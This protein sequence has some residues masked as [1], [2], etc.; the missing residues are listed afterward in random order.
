ML[1]LSEG[2]SFHLLD[3]I[4]LGSYFALLAASGAYFAWRARRQAHSA[5]AYFLGETAMPVWAVAISI[6]ATVQSAATF[7]GAPE[8]AF[9]GNLAYLGTSLG[10]V[11]AASLLATVFIPAYYRNGVGTPYQLLE[12]RFGSGAKLATSWAYMIGRV[13]ASGSRV[14]VGAIPVSIAVFGDASPIHMSASIAAFMA[15]GVVYTLAGGITSVIWTDVIQVAVYL[16]AAVLAVVLLAMKVSVPFSEVIGALASGGPGGSSKLAVFPTGFGEHGFDFA[17]EMNLVTMCTGFVLICLASHGTDQDLVQRMLTCKSAAR[18]AWS[19]VS[20]ILVGIPA[21]AVFM[22]LGLLLWVYYSRPELMG[23]STAHVS[24]VAGGEVLLRYIMNEM[25]AGAAGLMIAGVM[26][27]GPA[28]INSGLNSMAST[29]V[30]DVYKPRVS[31]RTDEH[32]L[33]VGRIAVLSWGVV[34]AAFALACIPWREHSGQSII[35]FV[36]SVMNFAYAGLLGVFI[37]ALFTSRGSTA[38]AIAALAAGFVTVFLLRPEIMAMW[39]GRDPATFGLKLA[40]PWQLV[41]GTAVATAVCC[42]SSK[43]RRG[44]QP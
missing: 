32:Y 5:S 44:A 42:A 37:T 1:T 38:S 30:S 12:K 8:Q 7:T 33:K 25:P 10:S 14:Y 13:F 29:F 2:G 23:G 40:F 31:G 24:A 4:V 15:F 41:I 21:V 16:G 43:S 9:N 6:L 11:I 26:A 27:A 17:G 18:G 22:V 34:L 36:L 28:G 20:G 35:G 3:W 19:V 39:L